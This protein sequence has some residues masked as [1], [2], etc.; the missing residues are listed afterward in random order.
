MCWILFSVGS[1]SV[2]GRGRSREIKR[3][4]SCEKGKRHTLKIPEEVLDQSAQS[5]GGSE[6][7]RECGD[8]VADMKTYLDPVGVL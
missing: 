1:L 4:S 2:A 3:F 6:R 7:E 8:L 5:I